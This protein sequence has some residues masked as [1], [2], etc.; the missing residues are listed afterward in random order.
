MPLTSAVSG[1]LL[2]STLTPLL[3]LLSFILVKTTV[4]LFIIPSIFQLRRLQYIQN[5]LARAVFRTPLYSPITSTLQSLHSL[6][7]EQRI[8]YK[9]ISITYDVLHNSELTYLRR[10][11]IPRSCGSTL[12]ADCLF[13]CPPPLTSKLKFSDYSFRLAAPHL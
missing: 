3:P 1:I 7:I 12:S 5:A 6:K 8:R 2:T 13:L 4:T 10:R 9:V 11:I